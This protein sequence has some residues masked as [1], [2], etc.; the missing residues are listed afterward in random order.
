MDM[1]AVRPLCVFSVIVS[2]ENHSNLSL[3]AQD[4]A[5]KRCYKNNGAFR[6]QQML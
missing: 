6:K 5:R 2:Q 3:T 1:G 4:D